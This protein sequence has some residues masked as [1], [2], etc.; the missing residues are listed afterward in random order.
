[1]GKNKKAGAAEKK[2][3]EQIEKEEAKKEEIEE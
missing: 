2:M 3:P 1:M